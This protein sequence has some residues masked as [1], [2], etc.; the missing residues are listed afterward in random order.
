MMQTAAT[1][2]DG[3]KQMRRLLST[4][5]PVILQPAVSKTFIYKRIYGLCKAGFGTEPV[6]VLLEVFGRDAVEPIHPKYQF[7]LY[8]VDFCG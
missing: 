2:S 8:R 7:G 3:K 1:F 6:P 4:D 5:D